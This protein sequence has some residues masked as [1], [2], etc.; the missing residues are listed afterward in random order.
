MGKQAPMEDRVAYSNDGEVLWYSGFGQIEFSTEK[1]T[2]Y[3]QVQSLTKDIEELMN[4]LKKEGGT[5][6]RDNL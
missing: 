4:L 2:A 6:N 1:F 5:Q 3:A